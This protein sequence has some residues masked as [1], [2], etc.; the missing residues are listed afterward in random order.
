[1]GKVLKEG[2][3]RERGKGQREALGQDLSQRKEGILGTSI[4]CFPVSSEDNDESFVM[5]QNQ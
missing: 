3:K 2:K 1:M 5:Y 4:G